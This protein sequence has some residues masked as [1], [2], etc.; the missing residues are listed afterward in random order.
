MKRSE[1]IKKYLLC[2][3]ALCFTFS[4]SMAQD[5]SSFRS[6]IYTTYAEGNMGEWKN[7]MNEMDK[8]QEHSPSK[9]LLSELLIAQYGYIG[10]CINENRKKE[11]SRL[12]DR[13]QDKLR[14]L[15][16]EDPGN[17]SLMALEGAFMGYE[18]G[19]NKLKAVVTGQK[20]KEKIDAAVEKDPEAV[21]TLL[22]KANQLNF[23]PRLL[24]GDSGK[25]IEY[26]HKAIDKMEKVQ[27]QQKN[28]WI[29]VNTLVVLADT[30]EKM[31]NYTHACAVYEKI[32]NYDPG[33]KWV[34]EDLYPACNEKAEGVRY[35][36]P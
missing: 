24:G 6:R 7:V 9:E 28:S 3:A 25:A 8:L 5:I 13:A 4:L 15:I 22:E 30:Y 23:S 11:A 19:I 1:S 35:P 31:G 27:P 20:A 12:L 26:Y 32:M 10:H 21:R 29:Y 17:A 18:M 34:K 14:I 36:G 16:D 33:I 2:M